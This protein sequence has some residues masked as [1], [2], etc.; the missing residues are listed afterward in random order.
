[1]SSGGLRVAAALSCLLE[2]R[3]ARVEPRE[4]VGRLQAAAFHLVERHECG[5]HHP[6]M[7][8]RPQAGAQRVGAAGFDQGI[9]EGMLQHALRRVIRGA[10]GGERRAA[11][12]LDRRQQRVGRTGVGHAAE[13]LGGAAYG[14]AILARQKARQL[15]HRRGVAGQ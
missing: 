5:A 12:S 8:V 10:G 4:D 3:H 14:G 1:V 7:L 2:P 15:G 6:R 11:E 9:H 13:R